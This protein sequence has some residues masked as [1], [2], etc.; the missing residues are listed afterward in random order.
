MLMTA[1]LLKALWPE[2]ILLNKFELWSIAD[3]DTVYATKEH[4][5]GCLCATKERE[6]GCRMCDE[7]AQTGLPY[8]RQR[9]ADGVA[10]CA[11]AL[12]VVHRHVMCVQSGF[13][14][15]SLVPSVR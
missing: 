15:V 2:T 3:G 4:G 8:V 12:C 14:G 9:N 5:R 11:N 13:S 6:Q 1:Q 10:V 7:G